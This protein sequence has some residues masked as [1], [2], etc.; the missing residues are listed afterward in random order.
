MDLF[1]RT[2][3]RRLRHRPASRP[4][5]GEVQA[6]HKVQAIIEFELD[7]TIVEA[8]DNFLSVMGYRRDDVVGR[9]H[10]IFVDETTRASESYR[11]FWRRLGAGTAQT[12]LYRRVAKDGREVWIQGSYSPIL[13]ARGR[14]RRVIKHAIDVTDE[15]LKAA[16]M[17]GRLA[18]IDRAQAVI[19]FDLE[20]NVIECND[21]F[22][23]A[24]G[25]ARHEVVGHHHRMFVPQEERDGEAYRRF[26]GRLRAG[27]YHS[28]LFRRIRKDGRETWIQASYNP[29][30]DT[31]GRPFKVVKYATDVTR[32]TQAA[33]QLR[34]SLG[35]LAETVP[36]IA[37]KA[38]NVNL[39]AGE[40]THSADSGGV[41]V[42]ELVATIGQLDA[43]AQNMAEIIGLIDAIAFQTNILA[44]NAAVEAAR[45]GDQ[46][47]GFAVVAQEVRALAQRSAQSSRDIRE[48]VQATID[49]LSEG[50][51]RAQ[52]A[53][54]AMLAIVGATAQVTDRI[55]EIAAE[56]DAQSDG[57]RQV[58][59]AIAQMQLAD[60]AA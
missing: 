28:G 47:R 30:F 23:A 39:L 7:G 36:A 45:A 54:E 50:S 44:L 11:D 19:S 38:Q 4:L 31:A 58:N 26:W 53:G 21:N 20:G 35:T 24:M 12:G 59:Q 6:L 51:G 13:D 43:R 8:N 48:L 15:R 57:I 49:T 3:L 27:E 32:Q 29:I 17:E 18:A 1:P 5:A 22:L 46:G 34:Q 42:R 10:G 55:R 14:P 52:Q 25:Y 41:L 33:R 37:G 60:D 40:A 16:D 56:A 2:L 9:H